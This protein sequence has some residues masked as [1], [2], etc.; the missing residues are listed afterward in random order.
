M[1]RVDQVL[2]YGWLFLL[3]SACGRAPG[4][5]IIGVCTFGEFVGIEL[6]KPLAI[7]EWNERGSGVLPT[8]RELSKA[9]A[10][11]VRPK[12]DPR[13]Y[14]LVGERRLYPR[15]EPRKGHGPRF[16]AL[17]STLAQAAEWV[18]GSVRLTGEPR[19]LQ[20][21]TPSVMVDIGGQALTVTGVETR[22][23][24]HLKAGGANFH[25]VVRT[26]KGEEALLPYDPE[27]VVARDSE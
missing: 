18:G 1:I 3:V 25:L 5:D 17:E 23:L 6:D 21:K 19:S 12:E 24:G 14:L 13:G 7:Y 15:L 4:E 11:V 27:L 26:S 8:L 9:T 20:T 10:Q 16:C 2:L 22:V